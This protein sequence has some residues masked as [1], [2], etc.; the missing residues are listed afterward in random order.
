MEMELR[1]TQRLR[2]NEQAA[3]TTA[4][5]ADTGDVPA[6]AP[7]AQPKAPADKLSVSQQ[8]LTWLERQAE[9]DREREMRRQE[10]RSDSLSALESKKQALDG[11]DKK[12]KVQNKCQKIAA[13][14]MRGDR[15]PPEDLKYLMDN[16][17]AGYKLAMAMRREK[18]DPEDVESVLDEE[19]KNG[20]SS[21]KTESGGE[22]PAV[23]ATAMT[24][25]GDA[26]AAE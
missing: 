22:A 11:L 4:K 17:A 6:K 3:K 25:G 20:S 5:K 7:S 10:R 8:A 14:I 16:D 26:P 21:G 1:A 12:L 13:A 15:V 2:R 18:K 24:S 19:D 9:L 23:S